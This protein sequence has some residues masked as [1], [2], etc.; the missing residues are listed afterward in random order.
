M[1]CFSDKTQAFYNSVYT[2]K[3]VVLICVA[4]FLEYGPMPHVV[5][6]NLMEE[7]LYAFQE[8]WLCCGILIIVVI[9][10]PFEI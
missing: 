5:Y 6:S 8:R 10:E 3:N 1:K 9:W 4:I 2:R 7:I